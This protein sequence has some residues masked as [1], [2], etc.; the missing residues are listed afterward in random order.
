MQIIYLDPEECSRYLDLHHWEQLFAAIVLT[1]LFIK[2]LNSIATNS[3]RIMATRFVFTMSGA[4]KIKEHRTAGG[5]GGGDIVCSSMD[6]TMGKDTH[7][8]ITLFF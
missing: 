4:E 2:M 3:G 7:Y 6:P 1:P 8:Y 5:G